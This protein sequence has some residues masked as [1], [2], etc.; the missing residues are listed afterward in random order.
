[1]RLEIRSLRHEGQLGKASLVI[2]SLETYSLKMGSVLTSHFH[3]YYGTKYISNPQWNDSRKARKKRERGDGSLTTGCDLL[4]DACVSGGHGA[5]CSALV[6]PVL[7]RASQA[8]VVQGTHLPMQ[9]TWETWV[10][11]LGQEDPL[12]KEWQPTRVF[13]PWE[14]HGQRSPVGYR[15]LGSKE[16]DTTE[17]T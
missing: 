8:A 9:E 2:P 14:S 10:W 1:M 15:P 11:S 3:T 12:E 17:P 7:T 4:G 13:L 5:R 6:S 16:L